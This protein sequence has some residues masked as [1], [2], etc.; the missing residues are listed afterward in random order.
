MQSNRLT[1]EGARTLLG[2]HYFRRLW[3]AQFS[4]VTVVYGLGL[5][6]AVLVEDLTHSSA[7]T[8]LVI[9]SA[10]LPAFAGSLIS[11]AVVD[12]WGRVRVLLAGHLGRGLVALAFWAGTSW[13]PPGGVLATVY[14][15]NV[16]MALF[17]QLALTAELALLPELL[18]PEHLVQANS[19]FQLSSLAGEGLG[20][21]ALT[22]L[23]IK[24]AGAPTTGLAGA[25]LYLIALPLVAG[26]PR[27]ARLAATTDAK[28]P[29]WATLGAD[30][31]EGWRA[32]VRDRLLSLVAVQAT[33]A[34]TLLLVLLSLVPGLA[35]RY[36]GV[37]V[38]AAPLL[39]LPGGLAFVVGTL[40]IGRWER[41][42]SRPAWI[43]LGLTG[44]GA[45][46]G[47][48]A[49]L[50]S[51]PG[52]VWLILPL[53]L[54]MGMTL[55]LIIIPARTVLQEHP[56]AAI[57]GRVIAAQLALANAAAVVPL[58]MGGALADHFGIRPVM[59]VLGLVAVGAGAAG[60]HILR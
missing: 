37:G 57:R 12:R 35:A 13:L 22:P 51:A 16:A 21:V 17:T 38:E 48:M 49:A 54:G 30:V 52:A 34:A 53:I 32:I 58:L 39:L 29:A 7:Q 1:S 26:L 45:C 27:R 20:I 18:D 56:P 55:A 15:V 46:V 14:G 25:V 23:L 19:L 41:R 5:A 3:A 31:R 47:L 33:V 6:G 2:N 44:L 4:T 40:F 36:L 60:L 43:G 9:L 11:G 28:T 24:V 42:L 59:G 10:I 50:S 8:G